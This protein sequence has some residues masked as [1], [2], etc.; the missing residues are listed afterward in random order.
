MIAFGA[1]TRRSG[2]PSMHV[3]SRTVLGIPLQSHCMAAVNWEIVSGTERSPLREGRSRT[4][5]P[6][7]G[8]R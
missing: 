6:P 5:T 8:D 2:H 1:V 4:G 3:F 7:F